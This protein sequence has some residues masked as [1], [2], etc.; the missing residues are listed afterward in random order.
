MREF[1]VQFNAS[2]GSFAGAVIGTFSGRGSSGDGRSNPHRVH[3]FAGHF[4]SEAEM[5]AYC[6]TPVTPNGPEQLNLDLFEASIDT[7]LIDAVYSDQVLERLS[8]YFGRKERRRIMGKLKPGE[9]VILVPMGAFQGMD[10]RLHSTEK[11]RLIGY[12]ESFAVAAMMVN[13]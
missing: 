5:F 7:S 13:S 1:W 11:L 3:I 9:A 4:E 10:F 2:L 6:F 12:E 8:E